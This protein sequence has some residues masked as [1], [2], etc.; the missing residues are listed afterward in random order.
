MA[1][2]TVPV[3]PPASPPPS[4][5]WRL[6]LI[7]LLA[8]GVIAAA[9]GAG[10]YYYFVRGGKVAAV[11]VKPPQDP[12]FVALEPFTVNLQPGSRSRF[13]HVAV[14]LKMGDLK[15]QT[16]LVQYLP[17][18]RSRVLSTLS[19][20]TAESLLTTEEKDLLAADILTVLRQPFGANLPPAGI[21]SVMFTTFM[22]Q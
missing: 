19:N 21:S 16:Q 1:T 18:V 15:S 17:E 14:T 4:G 8:V 11:A 10:Y 6:V 13:L 22:L 2:T 9:A 3:P 5:K 7:V 12:I 20:R